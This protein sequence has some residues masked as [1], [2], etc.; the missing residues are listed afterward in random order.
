[1]R[2]K[3]MRKLICFTAVLVMVGW[4]QFAYA[5]SRPSIAIMNFTHQNLDDPKW[6]WLE[7]GLADMLVTDLART[8]HFR[9][10]DREQIQSYLEEIQLSASGMINEQTALKSPTQKLQSG[11]SI[12]IATPRNGFYESKEYTASGRTTA[13][14]VHAAFARHSNNITVSAECSNLD[15]LRGSQSASVDYY[16][17]PEILHW[18]DRNTEWSGKKD[19]LE[20][21]VA[22]YDA[23]DGTELSNIIISGKSKWATFGGD[24]PQDLL[25]EPLNKYVESLY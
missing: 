10:V 3:F 11:K 19:K 24:H 21:K 18:E 2:E 1:M 9:V 5:D 25:P 4:A 17:V 13:L 8:D 23:A 15:C 22:V 20:I 6:K 12:L 16:V 14:A 7:K